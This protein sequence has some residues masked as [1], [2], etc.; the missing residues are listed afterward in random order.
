MYNIQNYIYSNANHYPFQLEPLL[1]PYNA[2]EPYIDTKTMQLHHDK[3]LKT[4]VDNLNAAIAPY[5]NLY[6]LPLEA[7]IQNNTALPT[8]I[9][10]I[11]A[12]NAGGVF[13]HNFYFKELASHNLIPNSPLYNEIVSYFG[14]YNAFKTAFISSAIGVFGSGYAWLVHD[15]INNLKIT[16]TANQDTPLPLG[17]EPLLNIDVWEHAYYL[18]HYSVRANYINDWFHAMEK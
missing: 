2:L 8:P 14:S 7:L 10:T 11:V 5:P 12:H 13:N 1:Y 3:H 15:G 9:Q 16:T 18:K 6:H 4:Y 17:Y